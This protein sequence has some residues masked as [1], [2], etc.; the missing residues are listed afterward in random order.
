MRRSILFLLSLFVGFNVD[1]QFSFA[2]EL[3]INM[4]KLTIDESSL[5]AT[6][7]TTD[8]F[9][10]LHTKTLISQKSAIGF[11]VEYSRRGFAVLSELD[12]FPLTQEP[13]TE[14]RYTYLDFQPYYIYQLD[15]RLSFGL[16]GYIGINIDEEIREQGSNWQ[17][18]NDQETVSGTDYGLLINGR[19]TINNFTLKIEYNH[20]LKDVSNLLL[21]DINGN[22]IGGAKQKL[23]NLQVGIAYYL[24]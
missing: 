21:T 8:F 16:G 7:S 3:G 1:G 11:D 20:G 4:G 5:L 12:S 14:F 18:I 15:D 6:G 13:R 23:R 2:P 9:I 22:L 19:Y 17:D 10:G 24:I